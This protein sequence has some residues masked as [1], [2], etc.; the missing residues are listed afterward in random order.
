[1]PVEPSAAPF[2]DWN[3][4]IT[5]ECY[6]P[7]AFARILDNHGRTLA[8]VNNFELMSFNVGPT[9]ATWLEE[10][11]PDVHR[12]MVEADAAAGTAIAQAYHHAILPL[13][14]ARDRR[15]EI[16]WGIADFQHRFGRRPDGMWMP[17]TAVNDD[18]LADLAEE[19]ITFT[20]IAPG[21]LASAPEPGRS[22][23]WSDDAG[24]SMSLVVYDGPLSHD[25]AFGLGGQ[26]A[27]AL[28]ERAVSSVP[29]GAMACVATDGETFGH[30]HKFTERAVAYALAVEAP[31]RG[32]TVGSLAKWLRRH[33]PRDTIKVVES[34]W[35]CAH[36]VGRWSADC[37][38]STGGMDGANQ[39]WRAPL[40]AALELLRVHAAAAFER[41]GAD[42]FLDPWAARDAYIG[43]LLDA[44]RWDEF[45]R[46]HLVPGASSAVARVLLESQRHALAM[47]TSCGWFFWD[48]SGI[49]T[50]QILR[51]AACCMDELTTAG[52]LPPLSGF[53]TMLDQ[54]VSNVRA[55]GT[56]RDIWK[57]HVVPSRT[58]VDV[59]GLSAE[60]S[61]TLGPWLTRRSSELAL[62]GLRG[63]PP[64][65]AVA[66][67]L[68]SATRL[69]RAIEAGDLEE[70]ERFVGSADSGAQTVAQAGSAALVL[71]VE[72]AIN[73]PS[74]ALVERVA[75]LIERARDAGVELNVERAQEPLYVAL[76][77]RRR[78]PAPLT[79]LGRMLG[80]A[81]GHLGIPT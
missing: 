6:R 60:M 59:A 54:A 33:P 78:S 50:I 22:Y 37:G 12:R 71:L 64:E 48:I 44:G 39:K 66:R 19:G 5:D 80:L 25:V 53:L 35:S 21:Q 31:R 77:G 3:A 41:L 32:L 49:E 63:E 40:R 81:V 38:C 52:D 42:V 68:W 51:H 24:H 55:E 14:D 30:H 43:P 27:Q 17:E 67:S 58:E 28:V 34:A 57:V 11:A 73:R 79:E 61:A 76:S 1:M 7:N 20:I 18:V 9:L 56:G 10:H 45:A 29:H 2:H 65:L 8:I 62:P 26:S 16:R 23:R 46:R 36:G 72:A 15:T 47:F 13:S 4:R 74:A 75:A 70:L 69:R